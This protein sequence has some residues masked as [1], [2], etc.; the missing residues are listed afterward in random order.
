MH[1]P[2]VD[3]TFPM[4]TVENSFSLIVKSDSISTADRK[5]KPLPLEPTRKRTLVVDDYHPSADS[6]GC[7]MELVFG[8]EVRVVYNG[9]NALAIARS[10]SPDLVLLDIGMPEMNGYEVCRAM[11]REPS[12]K[13]MVIIAQTGW[14]EKKHRQCSS[15]AGFDYHLVKPLTLDVLQEVLA[16]METMSN[17]RLAAGLRS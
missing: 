6:L 12:L 17:Q 4:G 5:E 3:D 2:V 9:A 13:N 16:S 11:R 14:G 1:M 7:M 10:F 8:H 15:E